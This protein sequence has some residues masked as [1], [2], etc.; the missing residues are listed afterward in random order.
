MELH[1]GHSLTWAGF[2]ACLV[3]LMA[4]MTPKMIFS[5]KEG[6]HLGFMVITLLVV[7][8]VLIVLGLYAEIYL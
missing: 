8:I 2:A 1:L 3:A 4:M 7:G 5:V 6:V